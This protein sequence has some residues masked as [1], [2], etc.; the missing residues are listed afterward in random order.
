MTLQV[1]FRSQFTGR[2]YKT[3]SMKMAKRLA[4]VKTKL[5]AF[6]ILNHMAFFGHALRRW[7]KR[8]EV[9]PLNNR[10]DT[11]ERLGGTF[12]LKRNPIL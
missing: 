6:N 10:P 3:N 2:L 4:G 1:P 7:V 11:L 5:N 9:A 12:R 8:I